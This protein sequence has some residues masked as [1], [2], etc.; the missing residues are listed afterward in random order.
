LLLFKGGELKETIVGLAAKD[1]LVR[2]IDKHL[3]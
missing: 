1:D 3:A 2:V